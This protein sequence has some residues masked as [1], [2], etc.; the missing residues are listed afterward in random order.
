[1]LGRVNWCLFAGVSKGKKQSINQ[2]DGKKT[3]KQK[4]KVLQQGSSKEKFA[5]SWLVSSLKGHSGTILGL[6]LTSSNKF[7]ASCANGN[8]TGI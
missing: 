1:M 3:G 5:H 8:S 2:S 4:A 7:L 6:D